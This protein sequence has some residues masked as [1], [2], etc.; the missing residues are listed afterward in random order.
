MDTSPAT[1][2]ATPDQAAPKRRR[3]RIAGVVGAAALVAGGL[4]IA[5]NGST[6]TDASDGGQ[7]AKAGVGVTEGAS[8]ATGACVYDTYVFLGEETGRLTTPI[9]GFSIDGAAV[10]PTTDG[11]LC[12]YV[13]ASTL[14]TGGIVRDERFLIVDADFD[15]DTNE[16]SLRIEHPSGVDAEGTLLGV[17]TADGALSFSGVLLD[18]DNEVPSVEVDG[19]VL[20]SEV[21]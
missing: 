13:A 7:V 21:A 10:S 18:V 3:G 1:D 9:G 19:L 5:V 11:G 4:A 12:G 2:H 20:D 8:S 14:D 16:L 6:D 17:P 15:D